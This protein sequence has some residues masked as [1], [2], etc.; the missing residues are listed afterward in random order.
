MGLEELKVSVTV[1]GGPP[2]RSSSKGGWLQG[3]NVVSKD[4][5]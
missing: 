1:M 3:E 5:K 2:Q 4:F